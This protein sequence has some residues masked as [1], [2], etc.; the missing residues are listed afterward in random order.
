MPYNV[1]LVS[2]MQHCKAIIL[3]LKKKKVTLDKD[4]TGKNW[5]ARRLFGESVLIER[6]RINIP[7]QEHAWHVGRTRVLWVWNS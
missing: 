6:A 7:R 4:L 5:G 1:V 2:A 3:Q